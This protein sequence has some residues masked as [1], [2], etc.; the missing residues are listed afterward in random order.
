MASTNDKNES[1]DEYP[2][3]T[4]DEAKKMQVNDLRE[5]MKKRGLNHQGSKK[6]LVNRIR[7]YSGRGMVLLI[8][9]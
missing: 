4:Y 1:D 2:P 9:F 7:Y 3:I 5:E 6:K 8:I